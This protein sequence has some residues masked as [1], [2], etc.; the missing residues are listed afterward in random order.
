MCTI[1]KYK[2]YEKGYEK[3][4]PVR[5]NSHEGKEI[6]IKYE[7]NYINLC[8]LIEEKEEKKCYMPC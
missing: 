7:G 4:P 6:D 5:K 2:L 8:V 1:I 3:A